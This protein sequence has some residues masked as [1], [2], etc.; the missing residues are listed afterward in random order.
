MAVDSVLWPIYLMM[1]PDMSHRLRQELLA[2]T[3]FSLDFQSSTG[4]TRT[5]THLSLRA[6][7]AIA[8]H[9]TDNFTLCEGFC[10]C[11]WVYVWGKN[12]RGTGGG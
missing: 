7:H 4:K 3:D 8:H 11:M 2:D 12:D 9:P 5:H 1:R 6:R 10:V